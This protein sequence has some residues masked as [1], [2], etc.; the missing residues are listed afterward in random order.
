MEVYG[1]ER[2]IIS[3]GRCHINTV[4]DE[5]LTAETY[6]IHQLL[7]EMMKRIENVRVSGITPNM[8]KHKVEQTNE[9]TFAI[10]AIRKYQSPRIRSFSMA[11]AY[12]K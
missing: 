5:N 9:L 8:F 6:S 3:G 4:I 7:S 11:M 1:E 10:V 12:S 2:V